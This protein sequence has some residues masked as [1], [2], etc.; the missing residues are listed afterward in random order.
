ML[1]DPTQ[2]LKFGQGFENLE[3][4]KNGIKILRKLKKI[5]L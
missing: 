2:K 3:K 1:T 5:Y 4:L